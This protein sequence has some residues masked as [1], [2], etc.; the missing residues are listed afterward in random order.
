MPKFSKQMPAKPPKKTEAAPVSETKAPI[1][2]APAAPPKRYPG[3]RL[4]LLER[5]EVLALMPLDLMGNIT[6]V[7]TIID[8]VAYE[9]GLPYGP[10]PRIVSGWRV[11]TDRERWYYLD[12]ETHVVTRE[13]GLPPDAVA[14]DGRAPFTTY[15]P[16]QRLEFYTEKLDAYKP[17]RKVYLDPKTGLRAGDK[18][19][20]PSVGNAIQIPTAPIAPIPLTEEEE[21]VKAAAKHATQGGGEGAITTEEIPDEMKPGRVPAGKLPFRPISIKDKH[22]AG[23]TGVPSAKDLMK[24]P[25]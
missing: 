2:A 7:Q 20:V 6:R 12:A 3:K 15:D 19:I 13:M 4:S 8:G 9:N 18:L 17:A 16:A 21:K 24:E 1:A 5:A 22:G 10:S 14:P 23:A 25:A 11:R